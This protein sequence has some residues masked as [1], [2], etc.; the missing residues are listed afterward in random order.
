VPVGVRR[1]YVT[2]FDG[3]GVLKFTASTDHASVTSY[4]AR[5][6]AYG[7]TSPVVVSRDMGVPGRDYNDQI[8]HDLSAILS[9]LTAGVYTVTVLATMPTTS[10]E[11]TGTTV[12]VPLT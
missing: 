4:T 12:A 3:P 9:P 7:T 11:S 2:A 1:R 5:V 6:Y 8:V 10:A